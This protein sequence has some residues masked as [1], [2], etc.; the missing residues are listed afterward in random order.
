MPV[1]VPDRESLN[2]RVWYKI[3]NPS[4]N[5]QLIKIYTPRISEKNGPICCYRIFVVKLAPQDNL[6]LI[7]PPEEMDVYTYQDVSQAQRTAAY[8]AEMFD[9]NHIPSE[10]IIGDGIAHNGSAAC[11]RC[12]GLKRKHASNIGFVPEVLIFY[13]FFFIGY[14]L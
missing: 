1:T 11:E 13:F 12:I 2:S 14:N 4:D 3:V 5:R 8:L 10:I 6:R 7:R 9:G